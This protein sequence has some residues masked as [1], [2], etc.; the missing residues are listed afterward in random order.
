MIH[1]NEYKS[2]NY[3][4]YKIIGGLKIRNLGGEGGT[5]KVKKVRYICTV[6]F[7]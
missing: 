6:K 4:V 2:T 3:K 5:Q 1:K 7:S